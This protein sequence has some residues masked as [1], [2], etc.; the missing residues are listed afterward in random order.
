MNGK[1][2]S[3]G[4]VVGKFCPLHLG[5]E[6]VI[7]AA[8]AACDE[9]LMISYTLLEFAPCLPPVRAEWLARRFPDTT[10]LVLDAASLTVACH[11]HGLKAP[12]LPHNDAPEDD[13][14]RFVA[15]LC[16]YLMGGPVDAV[17]TSEGYGDGFAR[18]LTEQFAQRSDGRARPRA[19]VK[20]VCV[21]RARA[22]LSISGTQLRADPHGLRAWMAPG[23]YPAF[24][25]RIAL[26][27]AESTGKTALAAALAE[28]L[29]TEWVPEYGRERWV[30]R[31]GT[32]GPDDLLTIA[33]VQVAREQS[34]CESAHRWLLCDTTPL[35][36]LFY[37]IEEF[38]TPPTRL[39]ELAQ[40]HYQHVWLLSPDFGFVQDETRRGADFST[41]QQRWF[42]EQ[43]GKLPQPHRV[44]SGTLQQRVETAVAWLAAAT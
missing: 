3:R 22:A 15:W 24:V 6:L 33:E 9:L 31:G 10:R 14:R 18:V 38:G 4:L 29:G 35:T 23:V 12:A 41:R 7:A 26:L 44:L 36:T 20:H 28:R 43:L 30:E 42:H 11:A 40:R 21:D 2:F 16:L 39:S 17:F 5:H 34:A 1:R 19:P 8:R 37:F 32:L 25:E 13:H 27:G